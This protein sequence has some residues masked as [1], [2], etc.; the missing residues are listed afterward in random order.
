MANNVDVTGGSGITVAT[1]Q[2][3]GGSHIQLMKLVSGTEDATDR[4]GGDAANG[5]DVDVTRL[6]ALAAGTNAIGKLAANSGV[7]IGD[8]DV[9]SISAGENVIGRVGSN[10]AFV[11][12]TLNAVSPGVIAAAGDYGAL[13]VL[14]QSASNGVGV[15]WVLPSIAR[16]SGY[17]GV[18]KR[19]IA[20]LSVAA[21]TAQLRL[22][23]F[24]AAPTTTEKDD[25]AAFLLDADDR[26]KYLGYIDLPALATS[27]SSEVSF[28]QIST[29]FAFKCVGTTDLYFI[30]QTIGAFTNETAGMTLDF[31]V[32]ASQD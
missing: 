32:T 11:R 27:G 26:A 4:I 8:V 23:F 18:I 21:V 15:H 14:S 10:T 5:L 24:N 1:D 9:T 16:V 13:D 12:A 20:T 3:S 25:N 29:E 28:A 7:D 31:Q 19:I 30:V 17:G 22:H 6:P 2:V